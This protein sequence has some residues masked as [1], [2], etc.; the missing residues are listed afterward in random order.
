M[1]IAIHANNYFNSRYRIDISLYITELQNTTLEALLI[2][3]VLS[4]NNSMSMPF[5]VKMKKS[6]KFSMICASER[7]WSISTNAVSLCQVYGIGPLLC[8]QNSDRLSISLCKTAY[9][10]VKKNFTI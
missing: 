10:R 5:K 1:Q 2:I 9:H 8:N 7:I 4:Y 6:K 3:S